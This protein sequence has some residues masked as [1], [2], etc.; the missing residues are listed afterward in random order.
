MI[1][2]LQYGIA[3]RRLGSSY[4]DIFRYPLT[5]NALAVV[6]ASESEGEERPVKGR[7]PGD[8]SARSPACIMKKFIQNNLLTSCLLDI[9]LSMVTV[10]G[11]EM[12]KT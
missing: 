9:S 7:M 6:V 4:W 12:K 3:S 10:Y 1:S 2:D 8:R 11:R 5:W